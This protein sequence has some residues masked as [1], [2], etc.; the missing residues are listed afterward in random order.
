L[1]SYRRARRLQWAQEFGARHPRLALVICCVLLTGVLAAC[2]YQLSYGTYLGRGWMIAAAAGMATSAGL[3]AATL[4]SNRRHSPATGWLMTA[5]L[6]L[7]LISASAIRFPFPLGPYGRVQAFFN[8]V[9]A[10][11]LG[12]EA[13]TCAG[14]I[15]LM[16]YV[17]LH[18]RARSRSRAARARHGLA[19]AVVPARL[20][21]PEAQAATWRAGRLIAANGTVTWLSLNGDVEV[22]LT[23]ACQALPVLPAAALRQPRETMLATA[24][25]TVEVDV[26]AAALVALARQ[27]S[28]SAY[29]DTVHPA[30]QD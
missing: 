13:M 12:Y 9:K 30:A 7:G 14:I 25:D 24:N 27:S 26:P 15:A 16:A 8:A 28:S 22:D 10:A 20:R 23:A 21:F 6:V 1:R 11:L 17:L 3:S 4:I 19:R 29:G 18:P 5:W 2:G